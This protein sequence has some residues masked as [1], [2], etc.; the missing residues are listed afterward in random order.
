MAVFLTT[1]RPLWQAGCRVSSPTSSE[2][3]HFP[4]LR[5][6]TPWRTPGSEL[7]ELKRSGSCFRHG[8]VRSG[9][10]LP[11]G[12]CKDTRAPACPLVWQSREFPWG[13]LRFCASWGFLGGAG[14]VFLLPGVLPPT[15]GWLSPPPLLVFCFHILLKH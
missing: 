2:S 11:G 4:S 3:V 15:W 6:P 13:P 14:A 9:V 8:A 10:G 12:A 7:R 1:F 5:F